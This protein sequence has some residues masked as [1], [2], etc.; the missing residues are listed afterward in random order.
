MKRELIFMPRPTTKTALIDAANEQW[1][2]MW[3]LID[4][5]P[6]GAES[7]AFDFGDNPKL[8][9]AHWKWNKIIRDVLVHLYEWHRLLLGWAMKKIKKH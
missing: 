8:K 5:I 2:T 6:D 1:D 7:V 4:S 3:K 9:E